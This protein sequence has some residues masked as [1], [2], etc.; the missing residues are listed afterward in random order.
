MA[1][2]IKEKY[3]NAGG[4]ETHFWEAGMGEPVV[5]VHGGGP[6]VDSWGN[7]QYVINSLMNDGFRVL[8]LDLVGFAK[9]EAPSPATFDYS[10][11]RLVQHVVDFINELDLDN[12][13]LV[14]QSFGG[15]VSLGVAAEHPELINKLVLLGPSAR[16]AYESAQEDEGEEEKDESNNELDRNEMI[17]FAH[18]MSAT[19]NVDFDEM[20][21]RRL[22]M[23]N[24]SSVRDAYDAIWDMIEKGG[25]VYDDESLEQIPHETLI[26]QGKDDIILD[27]DY[28]WF[29]LNKIEN[30]SLYVLTNAGHWEMID[31]AD[32]VAT[33]MS[34]FIRK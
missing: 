20:V 16:N 30:A 19:G 11:N 5:L 21:D 27:L 9:T 10:R 3:V 12:P 18:K 15:S 13:T 25:L 14:G 34:R 22:D 24:Q 31:Q 28:S 23:W 17:E 8:A 26:F 32:E 6:G 7:W 4:I 29:Y 1:N 33:M 2:A